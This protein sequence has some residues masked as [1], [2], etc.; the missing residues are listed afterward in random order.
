[1][2]GYSG[3]RRSLE[4]HIRAIAMNNFGI[5]FGQYAFLTQRYPEDVTVIS[6]FEVLKY[7]TANDKDRMKDT[8]AA[9]YYD[10]IE[11]RYPAIKLCADIWNDFHSILM[12]KDPDKLDGFLEKYD[13]SKISPFVNGIKKDIAPVKAAISS[14]VSSGFVEGGNCRY[15]ATKRLMFGRSSIHHL[16]LKTYTISIIMRTGKTVSDLICHWF[17]S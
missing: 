3:G 17:Q 1:N 16:F 9:R 5:Q 6:R 2:I 10:I 12:G 4:S 8:D 15:K 7:I 13:A 11:Q 14:P